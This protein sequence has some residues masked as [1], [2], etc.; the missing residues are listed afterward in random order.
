LIKINKSNLSKINFILIKKLETLENSLNIQNE[1]KRIGSNFLGIL[2]DL[3]RRPE[4]AAKELGVTT[5]EIN[6]IIEGKKKLIP[7]IINRAAKIWPINERDFYIIRDDCPSGVKIMTSVN[8]EKSSRIMER[9][10]KPYYD[11]RDTAMS[12]LAPFRPEWIMELCYVD[13]N[14]PTNPNVQWNNGHFM[15]QFTYFIGEVNFYYLDSDGKKQVAVMNTGDSMYIT[16]FT[17]H[18]FATRAGAEQNGLIIAITYGNKLTGDIQQELS[19]ISS[20]LGQEYAL[21][22]SSRK[23]A[24]SSLLTFHREI[25]SVSIKELSHRSNISERE[26]EDFENNIS[27]PS[28]IELQHLATSLKINVRDLLPNEKIE[29]KV[30]LQLHEEG[31]N[32][33]Y[34]E[35]ENYKFH[36]LASSSTLPYSKAFEIDVLSHDDSSLDLKV[37]LHQYIYNIGNTDVIINWSYNNKKFSEIIHPEDSA[38]LKP[39]LQHNFRGSGKL[40]ALRIG[41]KITGD[42]QRELS[43]VGK[44]NVK[45]AINESMQWF[46]PNYNN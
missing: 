28:E 46:D 12:S 27:I 23:H 36:D 11:Y 22:F 43:F 19:S 5:K 8:S 34:P 29:K 31:K 16:P 25:G 35:S 2:N 30:I 42:S 33:F 39:F 44:T 3:K 6:L 14:D 37:G 21:D 10:G 9:A 15:H 41:G 4:D 13:D 24:F 18:T 1:D 7:E 38:Y 40:L 17:P 45:R 26:I 32:W 20:E